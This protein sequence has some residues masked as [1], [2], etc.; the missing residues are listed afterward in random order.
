ME[1]QSAAVWIAEQ[2]NPTSHTHCLGNL[3][4]HILSFIHFCLIPYCSP[5]R[6]PPNPLACLSLSTCTN[7]VVDPSQAESRPVRPAS[8]F[9]GRS[10]ITITCWDY[11]CGP[12]SLRLGPGLRED[13]ES[14]FGIQ[15]SHRI[16][17]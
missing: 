8:T 17:V 12:L 6:G 1:L 10:A 15:K 9:L 16:I 11:G 3:I 5:I 2:S 13:C 14:S 4:I 7:A